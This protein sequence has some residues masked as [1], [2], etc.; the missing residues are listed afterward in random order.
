MKDYLIPFS[1]ALVVFGLAFL[2]LD[3]VIMKLQGLTL[4]FHG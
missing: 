1:I 3:F 4:I 2:T